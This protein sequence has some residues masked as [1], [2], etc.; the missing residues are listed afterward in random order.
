MGLL[1]TLFDSLNQQFCGHAAS[2]HWVSHR[3]I[4]ANS[5]T[6]DVAYSANYEHL[7]PSGG[8]YWQGLK[9]GAFRRLTGD[10]PSLRNRREAEIAW[11][12]H[13]TR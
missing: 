9:A 1:K 11:I 5:D 12:R 6:L 13:V 10:R 4:G 2:S 3:T 8:L 7:A